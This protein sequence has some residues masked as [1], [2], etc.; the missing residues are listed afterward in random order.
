MLDC[1]LLYNIPV[2]MREIVAAIASITRTLIS[3]LADSDFL[4]KTIL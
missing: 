2:Q 4:F 1:V 3:Q